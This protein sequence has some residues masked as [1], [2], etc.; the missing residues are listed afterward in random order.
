MSKHCL[1][2]DVSLAP[3]PRWTNEHY[4]VPPNLLLP[5]R[6]PNMGN[7]WETARN[8]QRPAILEARARSG[9]TLR[10]IAWPR[11]HYSESIP[12][13]EYD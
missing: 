10:K 2:S 6:A 3:T 9:D 12:I 4:G 5:Y 11:K 8:P 13:P 7:G 1:Q